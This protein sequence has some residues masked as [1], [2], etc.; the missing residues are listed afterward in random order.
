MRPRIKINPGDKF[1]R[2]TVK[3][4]LPKGRAIFICDCGKKKNLRYYNVLRKAHP[5]KSCGC[6]K[7]EVCRKNSDAQKG[8]IT[9]PKGYSAITRILK[10]YRDG[11]KY[12]SL[13]FELDREFVTEI[14]K[15]PC[16]YC[17]KTNSLTMKTEVYDWDYNGIDRLD[18]SIGYTKDN[19]V[20]CCKFCNR[21]KYQY[22]EEEFIEMCE[23]V[24]KYQ[25]TI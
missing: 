3:E 9:K 6:Y 25:K 12:R 5:T 8:A 17:G 24:T 22:S 11:A 7:A 10:Q 1:Y 13:V 2:L 15:K 19:C 23:N 14:T 4:V 18:N 21:A 20:P 16:R